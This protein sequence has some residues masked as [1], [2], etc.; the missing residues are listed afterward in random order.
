MIQELFEKALNIN[1]PWYVKELNFNSNSKRLDIYVDF[2]RGST[3]NYYDKDNSVELVDFNSHQS[4][5]FGVCIK[6]SNHLERA[7]QIKM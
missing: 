7:K 6:K 5:S 2:K 4:S 1:S 3:F